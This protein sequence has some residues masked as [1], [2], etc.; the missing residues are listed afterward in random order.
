MLPLPN[1][2]SPSSLRI[3]LEENGL[4]MQKK[5]G[6]NFLI[7]EATRQ[8]LVHALDIQAGDLVWE[9]GPGLGALTQLILE[10]EARLVAF[11]I[12]RGFV[13]ILEKLFGQHPHFTLVQGDGL[14]TVSERAKIEKPHLFIGNLPYNIGA[15]LVGQLIEEK[16]YFSRQVI[17]VQ[18]E[19]AER[20]AGKAG[21]KNYSSISVLVSSIYDIRNLGTI[22]P[23][24]FW[25]R[26]HINSASLLLTLKPQEVIKALP[27]DLYLITKILFGQRRKMISNT[28]EVYFRRNSAFTSK[29][30]KDSV[31]QACLA[32]GLTGKERVEVLGLNELACLARNAQRQME[33]FQ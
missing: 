8:K 10:K 17:T 15:N 13:N 28:L 30:V 23:S 21:S 33:E 2:N 9:L 26:P 16:I 24:S 29:L 18:K 25:P 6:Q 32:S 31:A 1:Y 7:H 14:K 4:G 27:R 11:E 3:F 5:F 19:V 12:D 20:I 22:G